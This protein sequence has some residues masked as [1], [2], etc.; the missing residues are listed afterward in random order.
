MQQAILA[1]IDY[2]IEMDFAGQSATGGTT[3]SA[4]TVFVQQTLF[5]DVYITVKELPLAGNV[6]VGKFYECLGLETQTSDN[7]VTFMERSLISGGVGKI[8]DRK[9]GVMALR[10]ERGRNHDVGR[11]R[12][13][14]AGE[15]ESADLPAEHAI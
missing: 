8:G 6:R 1:V 12:V 3:S 2:K 15:R 13:C 4:G 9:P 10:L 11:R 7:Y 14:L 5:K